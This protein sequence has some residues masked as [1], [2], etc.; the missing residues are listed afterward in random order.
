MFIMAAVS[1]QNIVFPAIVPAFFEGGTAAIFG[2]A[3]GGKRG[4]VLG[5]VLSAILCYGGLTTLLQVAQ[6]MADYARQFP[7]SDYTIVFNALGHILEAVTG[8]F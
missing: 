8:L 4:A 3:T 7:L 5:G 1:P 2:N 6:P